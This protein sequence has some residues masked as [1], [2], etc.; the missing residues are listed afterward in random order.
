M[1]YRNTYRTAP[2]PKFRWGREEWWWRRRRET[3]WVKPRQLIWDIHHW[4]CAPLHP[5]GFTARAT[6][7]PPVTLRSAAGSK[8]QVLPERAERK[9]SMYEWWKTPHAGHNR[10][11]TDT[12]IF[13]SS[14]LWICI[15]H[16]VM[17]KT[18]V[19]A[20]GWTEY[21]FLRVSLESVLHL[22]LLLEWTCWSYALQL[23][24][25]SCCSLPEVHRLTQVTS[26]IMRDFNIGHVQSEVLKD[27]DPAPLWSKILSF[28][29]IFLQI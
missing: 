9:L 7:F 6:C 21:H 4:Q 8:L 1:D 15:N 26:A 16:R 29:V 14:I 23:H 17:Q 11:W 3:T 5:C 20:P 19:S 18:Y 25:Q 22:S 10:S 28:L 12:A 2:F 27:A 24:F 13:T